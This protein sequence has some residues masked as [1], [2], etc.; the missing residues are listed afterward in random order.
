L[1]QNQASYIY[2]YI[3]V[4][5]P[6]RAARER[7]R[8][9][10]VVAMPTIFNLCVCLSMFFSFLLLLLLLVLESQSSSTG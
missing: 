8:Q 9:E 7:M 4:V 10:E 5:E 2:I 3:P 6:P 1:I